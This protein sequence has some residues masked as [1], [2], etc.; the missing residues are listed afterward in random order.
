MIVRFH[1]LQRN[2]NAIP[3]DSLRNMAGEPINIDEL[4][5]KVQ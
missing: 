4:F 5:E 3:I 2:A 1:F